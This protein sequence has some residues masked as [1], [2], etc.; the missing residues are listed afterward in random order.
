[1]RRLVTNMVSSVNGFTRAGAGP[2]AYNSGNL[3]V[4]TGRDR[5]G[6]E[7]A[8]GIY[9]LRTSGDLGYPRTMKILV[10]R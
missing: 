7:V 3:S 4:S 10:L 5:N 9:F 6:R 1:M 8:A 2:R